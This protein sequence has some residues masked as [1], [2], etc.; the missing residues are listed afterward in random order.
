MTLKVEGETRFSDPHFFSFD[1]LVWHD[2]VQEYAIDEG[3]LEAT[4]PIDSYYEPE[5]TTLS[6]VL[7]IIDSKGKDCDR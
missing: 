5:I 2:A 1:E 6:G 4:L 3:S 7:A